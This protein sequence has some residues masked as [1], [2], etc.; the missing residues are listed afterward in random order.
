MKTSI[1]T[2][3]FAGK[4]SRR[5][6]AAD[7]EGAWER[8]GMQSRRLRMLDDMTEEFEVSCVQLAALCDAVLEGELPAESL[9]AVGF[10][11]LA[12][13]YISFAETPEGDRAIETIHDWA[14][15]NINYPLT[16]STVAK[17]R[18]RL[19]TGEDLFT[20]DDIGR[21]A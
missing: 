3:F 15:P 8:T 2:G 4:V 6:L 11:L 21:P 10:G 7:L 16:L 17:F 5:D 13:D 18:H 1:L 19:V 9:E 12:A 20:R 14:V